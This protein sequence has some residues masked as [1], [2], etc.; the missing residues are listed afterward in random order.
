MSDT[1]KNGRK[2]MTIAVYILLFTWIILLVLL[3]G[4]YMLRLQGYDNFQEWKNRNQLQE[5]PKPTVIITEPPVEVITNTPMP[6]E[7]LAPTITGTPTP[8]ETLVPTITSTPTPE[9]TPTSTPLP[10][11]SPTEPPVEGPVFS[12]YRSVD[13]K[14]KA[15]AENFFGEGEELCYVSYETGVYFSIVFQREEVL[16]PLVYN[17]VTGEQM[18]GSDLIKESYFAIVKERLQ[19]YVA[20]QFPEEAED[21]FVS[22]KQAY[23]T[24]DYQ[25]FYLTENQ[26]VFYFDAN[27]LT[28]HHAAFSYATELSEAKAFFWFD[29]EGNPTGHAIRKLDPDKPMVAITYDDGPA[30]KNNLDIKLM[31]LCEQYGAKITYFFLGNRIVGEFEAVTKQLYENGHEIASH[32]YSH[33]NMGTAKPEVV[34][35]EVNKTNLKI[36][37][38]T[39]HV[40]DYVRLPGG[41]NGA[42]LVNL[43]QPILHWSLDTIDWRDRDAEIVFE[44]VKKR[45]NDGDII[46]IHSIHQ[47]SY[48]ASLLF[49]PWLAEQGYQMVTLSELFYYK[50]VTPENGVEYDGF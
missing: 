44:R 5:V 45:V 18:T 29:L 37:K 34:W 30:Y 13:E 22:Y 14:I 20:E 9:P 23:Q 26:L 15:E 32:T 17:L 2:A 38:V 31:E 48:E 33:T 35:P 7:T 49:I 24:E 28:E 21:D 8:V 10:T 42:Y 43:P 3:I 19:T 4:I 46:L 50:G 25:K 47:T 27:T 16:L 12:G 41:T 36:A 6:E 11:P 39:G 40:A 1:R